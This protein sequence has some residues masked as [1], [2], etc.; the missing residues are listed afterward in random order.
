MRSLATPIDTT[1]HRLMSMAQV[2]ERLGVSCRTLQDWMGRGNVTYAQVATDV[3]LFVDSFSSELDR[4]SSA[5]HRP[6]W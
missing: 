4:Q 5:P 6:V 3:Q 2:C 1:R